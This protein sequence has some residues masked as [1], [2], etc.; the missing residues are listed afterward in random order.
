MYFNVPLSPRPMPPQ[1]P[2]QNI[3]TKPLIRGYNQNTALRSLAP[4]TPRSPRNQLSS[5]T[6][7]VTR[8]TN[9]PYLPSRPLS[10][11]RID[12]ICEVLKSEDI[13]DSEINNLLMRIELRLQNLAVAHSKN[14]FMNSSQELQYSEFESLGPNLRISRCAADFEQYDYVDR[15][16]HDT[17]DRRI[18][19]LQ[20]KMKE[21][22]D[23]VKTRE[24][25]PSGK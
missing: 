23:L 16:G 9:N 22:S 17:K 20:K 1:S 7:I 21:I 3:N 18:N 5:S 11:S 14:P 6:K 25:I 24:S 15:S 10:H 13:D 19:E 4:P 12:Q 2:R 8:S